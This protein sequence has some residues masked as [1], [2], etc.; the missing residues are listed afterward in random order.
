MHQ[1]AVI[2]DTIHLKKWRRATKRRLHSYLRMNNQNNFTMRVAY[3]SVN[4]PISSQ[5]TAFLRIKRARM[6]PSTSGIHNPPQ[7]ASQRIAPANITTD[8]P[9]WT[10]R[11]SPSLNAGDAAMNISEATDRKAKHW[12]SSLRV[13]QG[14]RSNAPH[15]ATINENIHLCLIQ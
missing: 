9:M 2:I 12:K 1:R 8:A 7:N 11:V 5:K 3:T 6:I 15:T 4:N 14:M 13:S 10:L